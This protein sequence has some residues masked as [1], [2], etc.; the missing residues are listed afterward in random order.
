MS[1]FKVGQRVRV[2]YEGVLQ[3]VS[4]HDGMAVVLFDTG[5][6]FAASVRESFLTLIAEPVKVGDI[7]EHGAVTDLPHG[8]LVEGHANKHPYFVTPNG[9]ISES[10]VDPNDFEYLG[11]EFRVIYIP[12]AG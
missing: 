3:Y 11:G 10:A 7:I 1:E 5:G 9:V 8:S 2:E 12:D 6:D 4:P